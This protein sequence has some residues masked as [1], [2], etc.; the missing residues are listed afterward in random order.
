MNVIGA[1]AF[2]FGKRALFIYKTLTQIKGYFIRKTKW[3]E[4]I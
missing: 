1:Y 3:M 4:I 2:S